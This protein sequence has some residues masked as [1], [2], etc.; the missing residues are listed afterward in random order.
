MTGA[1]HHTLVSGAEFSREKIYRDTYTGLSS[2]ALPGGFSGT[3]SLAGVNIFSPQNNFLPFSSTPALLGQPI[4]IPVDTK[5]GYVIDTANYRDIV[6]VNWGVRLDD[7]NVTASN[8][9][10]SQSVH[11]DMFNWNVGVTVKPVPYVS[12]YAAYATSSN[13]VGVELDGRTAQYGGLAPFIAGNPNQVF[14]PERNK[15]AEVGAKI[16]LFEKRL[17]LTGALFTTEKD[18]ARESA[19]INGVANTVVAGAAYRVQGID[20]G[21]EGKITDR[22]SIFGGLVL[23]QVEE[24]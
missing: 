20:L 16:Q 1:W 6:L 2:E 23:M 9:Q 15:A 17:L 24:S 11:S 18:N 10:G 19:T 4:T 21:A 13:P 7:Y 22:W 14:S 3:G 5:A 12:L 8:F